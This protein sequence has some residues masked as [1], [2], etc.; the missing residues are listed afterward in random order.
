[1]A[2]ISNFNPMYPLYCLQQS[3]SNGIK[4]VQGSFFCK[5]FALGGATTASAALTIKVAATS[6]LAIAPAGMTVAF[7][8][9]TYR[10]TKICKK[11]LKNEKGLSRNIIK[12]VF[13]HF[14]WWS[15]VVPG[16]LIVG[17]LPLE[18]FGHPEKL[19]QLGVKYILSVVEEEELEPKLL[20]FP[21]KYEGNK[22]RKLIESPDHDPV[23]LDKLH[24][25]ADWIHEQAVKEDGVTYVHCKSGKARSVM[26]AVTYLWKYGEKSVPELQAGT[27]PLKIYE[28][29]K[30]HLRKESSLSRKQR[31]RLTELTASPEKKS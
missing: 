20:S 28:Y 17:A 9:A 21:C 15:V 8:Y 31:T 13:G 6:A 30:K 12:H 23:A 16:K 18:N 25:G 10:Y 4:R 3:V 26:V 2:A 24:Q 5:L 7:G 1:M 11:Q 29:F 27:D 22:N 19:K 14:N